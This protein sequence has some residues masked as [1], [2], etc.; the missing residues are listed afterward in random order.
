[1][2]ILFRFCIK[3]M[4]RS[5]Y[6]YL[7]ILFCIVGQLSK[8]YIFIFIYHSETNISG[9]SNQVY[10]SFLWDLH[11]I[12]IHIMHR[13]HKYNLRLLL[14]HLFN[15]FRGAWMISVCEYK[16]DTCLK[17]VVTVHIYIKAFTHLWW[18]GQSV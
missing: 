9:F 4:K 13:K 14:Y 8:L 10:I 2:Y 15:T 3:K 18:K 16:S 1:M 17:D 11:H 12:L 7:Y 6:Y 5:Y